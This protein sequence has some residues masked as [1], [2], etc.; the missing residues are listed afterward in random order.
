MTGIPFA[1]LNLKPGDRLADEAFALRALPRRAFGAHKW[2]VGGVVVVA[3]GP[4]YIGAAALCALGAGRTGAGIVSVAVPRGAMGAIAAIVPEAVFIVLPEGDLDASTKRA[5]D[6]IAE[7]LERSRSIVVGPGLGDDEYAGALLHAMFGKRAVRH[8]NGVGFRI[9]DHHTQSAEDVSKAVI[10]GETPAVIDADGLNWL[11]KQSDWWMNVRPRGLV[12]TPHVGEMSRLTGK[13][14]EE[15]LSDPVGIARESAAKWQQIVVLKYGHTVATD[16]DATIV[17]SDAPRSL[18]TAGSGDVFSGM[19]GAL[20][21]QGLNPLDA[22]GLAMY[23]GA[24]AAL[25]LEKRFGVLGVVAGDL[26]MA[27]AEVIGELE[28]KRDETRG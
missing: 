12:L 6:A 1:K 22:A 5:R 23:L 21:A 24:S 15:I 27:V 11:A 20:L 3:G 18:A 19:I 25:R 28:R 16:G 2:G 8:A 14:S 9:R 10:G 17:A 26:P 13:S 7:R 4:T